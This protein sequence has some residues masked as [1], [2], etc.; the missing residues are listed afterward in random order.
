MK[1]IFPTSVNSTI[2]IGIVSLHVARGNVRFL[3]RGDV[4]GGTT[5]FLGAVGR[6]IPYVWF[7]DAD[8]EQGSNT[9]LLPV[10]EEG[11]VPA[12]TH[13][14]P[15]QRLRQLVQ[16]C[17]HTRASVVG[18]VNHLHDRNLISCRTITTLRQIRTVLQRLRA[19]S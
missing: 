17:L 14:S 13:T 19:R 1:L 2:D 15:S 9:F 3:R 16:L 18:R 4:V 5:T 8:I 12:L 7:G 10:F 6:A 11:P